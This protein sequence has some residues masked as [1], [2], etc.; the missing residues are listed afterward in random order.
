MTGL[1]TGL[2]REL[3]LAVAAVLTAWVTM[4][5]WRVFAESSAGYLL[6]LLLGGLALAVTGAVARWLRPPR[7]VVL[8]T[9]ALVAAGLCGWLVAG[10]PVPTE[11]TRQRL[12]TAFQAAA[13]TAVSYNSPVPA[14]VPSVAPLLVAGGLACL[15][16]VDLLVGTLRRAPLA[17]LPLLVIYTLPVSV[18]GTTPDWWVFVAGV[19]GFLCLIFWQEDEQ[20]TRWGRA[21]VEEDHDSAE[22]RP[23]T[24]QERTGAIRGSAARIGGVA[25]ALALV[26]PPVVPTLTLEVF[27]GGRGLGGDGDVTIDNPMVDL[28]RDLNRPVDIPLL[29]IRTDNPRPSHLRLAVLSRFS[30]NAWSTGARE[31]PADQDARGEMPPLEGVAQG[32]GRTEYDA[33]ITTA[34]TFDSAWLP[35]PAQISRIDAAGPWQYDLA[36]MDFYAAEEGRTAA[37]MTYTLTEVALEYDAV[38][39]SSASVGTAEVSPLFLALPPEM[40]QVVGQLA[41][42]VTEG[43]VTRYEKAVALQSWFR[44]EGNFTYDLADGPVGNGVD[45]LERFLTEGPDGR[46]GYCEQFAAAMAVM[47]RYLGIP[48]RVATGFLL[49]TPV[50][51]GEWEYSAWDMHAWPE[52]YFPGSGWVRFEPTPDV[53][54]GSVPAYTTQRVPQAPANDLSPLASESQSATLR[55][56]SPSPAP[57]AGDAAGGGGIPWRGLLAMAA[58]TVALGLLLITPRSLRRSRR[59]RRWRVLDPAEAAWVELRDTVVD[60]G[61]AWPAGLSPQGTRSRLVGLLGPPAG[62]PGGD[63]ERP[64]RG[65]AVAGAALAALDRVV[66]AV[67]LARYSARPVP[68]DPTALRRDAE[69]CT[70]SLLAGLPRRA[71]RRAVW[72]PR[73]VLRRPSRT[74]GNRGRSPAPAADRPVDL[75]EQR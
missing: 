59:D 38:A 27:G 42:A 24:L 63:V 36:T 34:S 53:R 66:T 7:L 32:L 33:E 57:G 26:V 58:A 30:D 12:V 8:A 16:A 69:T 75:V 31:M 62:G 73:S 21:L 5:S 19:A 41:T 15:L 17:G 71:R 13:E 39:M 67:E 50:G 56:Q 9:Q 6:P 29:R 70:S 25:T 18:L 1:G 51:P 61:H 60:C 45:D 3:G 74:A 44:A 20:L 37:G 11:Q 49:P 68:G 14:D 64:R 43:A 47:A 54:A 55:P 48:A 10:S 4:L 2:P 65:P 52:L 72:L 35:T 40:P 22:D 28:R 23:R 46:V